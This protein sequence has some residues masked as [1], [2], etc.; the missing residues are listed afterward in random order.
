[1]MHARRLGQASVID[2]RAKGPVAIACLSI[3]ELL[4]SGVDP[5]W[6]ARPP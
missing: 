1:M 3:P 2:A 6:D 5:I 4:F